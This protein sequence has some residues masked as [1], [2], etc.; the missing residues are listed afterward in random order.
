MV[1]LGGVLVVFGIE[2]FEMGRCESTMVVVVET[3]ERDQSDGEEREV[4]IH[5]CEMS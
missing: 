1:K 2:A 5:R 3:E 4:K